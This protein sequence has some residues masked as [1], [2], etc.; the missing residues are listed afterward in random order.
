MKLEYGVVVEDKNN[1][2]LGKIDHIVMDTWTGRQRKYVI[3]RDA[4]RT[5]IFFSPE[6][7]EDNT[8][9]KVKLRITIDELE[10]N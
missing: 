5:D 3:R 8:K 7:V 4:P 2:L 9:E 6:H 10:N 1:N